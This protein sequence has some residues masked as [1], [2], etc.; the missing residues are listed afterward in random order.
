M[1]HIEINYI[2]LVYVWMDET[3]GIMYIMIIFNAQQ[4]QSCRQK[5]TPIIISSCQNHSTLTIFLSAGSLRLLMTAFL[6]LFSHFKMLRYGLCRNK[7]SDRFLFA[8]CPSLFY[9]QKRADRLSAVKMFMSL[10]RGRL[11][12]VEE[13]KQTI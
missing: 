7:I 5:Q 11:I 9:G 4:R 2:F 13:E 8:F 3:I 12:A 10:I 1:M 6:R